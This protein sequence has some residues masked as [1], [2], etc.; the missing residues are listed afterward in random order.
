MWEPSCASCVVLPMRVKI[1]GITN[2]DDARH[3]VAAGAD[4]LG[5][6]FYRASKRWISP[7]DA[8]AISAALPPFVSRVGLFVNAARSEIEQ[9]IATCG[10]DTIQ[11]HGDEE[12][13]QCCFSGVKVI[14]ALRVRGELDAA[15]VAR[16]RVDAIL[17]DAWSDKGYGGTGELC[18]WDVAAQLAPQFPLILA[19]GLHAGNVAAAIAA[20]QPYAVDVSSGVEAAPGRKDQEKVTAFIANAKNSRRVQHV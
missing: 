17:L 4:A 3:A 7:D 9:T 1:C 14:K 20:V 10:L 2:A 19:G 15:A 18:R 11:L 8:R 13:Q 16:Y 5:F 6:V 12:P